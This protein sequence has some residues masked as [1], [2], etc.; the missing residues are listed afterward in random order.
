M[1]SDMIIRAR[2]IN[3]DTV[4][5]KILMVH[6]M[7]TGFRKDPGTKQLVPAHYI[8]D[9]VIK[10]AGIPQVV[11]Q[12]AGGISKNP[13]FGFRFKGAKAGEFVAVSAVDNK[14]IQY[15]HDAIIV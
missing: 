15:E 4:E 14:G 8:T 2:M 6:I 7:E 10:L 13:F 9:V 12:C 1:A 5:V 11:V 3:G